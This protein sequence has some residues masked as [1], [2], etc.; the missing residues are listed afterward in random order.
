MSV[1]VYSLFIHTGGKRFISE[2][3]LTSKKIHA[4]LI[5]AHSAAVFAPNPL[6]EITD[7]E[8]VNES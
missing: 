3:R 4:S 6:L 7:N 2:V 1:P 5:T 8:S